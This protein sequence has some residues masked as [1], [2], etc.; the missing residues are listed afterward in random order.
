[1]NNKQKKMWFL[2]LRFFCFF[3]TET[4]YKILSRNETDILNN[5]ETHWSKSDLS[6][7][8]HL[9]SASFY[10]AKKDFLNRKGIDFTGEE[11]LNVLSKTSSA[12]ICKFRQYSFL[13][14]NSIGETRFQ[15][16]IW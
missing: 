12:A 4:E 6:L 3:C 14:L 9:Q 2:F 16:I 15:R 8:F 10:T 1:M 5:R 13:H 11:L 7:I